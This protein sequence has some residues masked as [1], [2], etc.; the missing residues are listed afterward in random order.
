[1]ALTITP[2]AGQGWTDNSTPDLSAETL[3]AV[4]AGITANS[5]A[6]NAIANAVVSQIVNDPNKIAS[7]A[8]LYAVNSNL[9]DLTSKSSN[10]G[11]YS[12]D[13]NDVPYIANI[14]TIY[15]ASDKCLNTPVAAVNGIM[16]TMY[17]DGNTYAIQRFTSLTTTPKLF[18]RIKDE[19]GWKAWVEK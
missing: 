9:T 1:M 12:G 4:D 2:Y 15:R 5:N 11:G 16:E 7:M 19:N 13:L 3:N 18:V 14:M 6:I 10:K 17:I 8:A